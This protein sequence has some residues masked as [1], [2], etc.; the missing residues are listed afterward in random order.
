[1]L[2]L[3]TLPTEGGGSVFF[4][5]TLLSHEDLFSII[6]VCNC[7]ALSTRNDISPEKHM[8]QLK[9]VSYCSFNLQLELLKKRAVHTAGKMP[10]ICHVLY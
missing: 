2:L 3:L 8:E 9:G 10:R 6:S 5:Q 4:L 7:Q 1:M